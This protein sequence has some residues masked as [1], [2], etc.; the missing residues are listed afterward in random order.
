[1]NEL[2]LRII[3][4]KEFLNQQEQ[5]LK[6][7]PWILKPLAFIRRQKYTNLNRLRGSSSVLFVRAWGT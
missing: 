1:M 2:Q 7:F 4:L 6:Q 5:Q 3:L